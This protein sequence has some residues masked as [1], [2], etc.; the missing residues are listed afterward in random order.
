LPRAAGILFLGLL[1]AASPAHAAPPPGDFIAWVHAAPGRAR[2]VQAFEAFLR[3]AGVGSVLPLSQMLLNASSWR[4]C[5]V[6]PYSLA[7]RALWP[8]IV[9]T[10][11]FIRARIV[12]ALGPVAALSGYRDAALNTCAGGAPK[13]AHALFYALDLT[14]LRFKNR[15]KM[16]AAVC[17]L[18]A[19]FG[20]A[21]H[22]GLGFYQGMRFHIDTDG[23]RRWGSDYHAATSPCAALEQKP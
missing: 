12:P 14:P 7:P 22:A 6:A 20:A 18:H 10:L 8:N 5:N 16:I 15:D 21:A 2:E 17:K 19:R 23:Y 1:L 3:R 4:A 13:S 9:P 11:R